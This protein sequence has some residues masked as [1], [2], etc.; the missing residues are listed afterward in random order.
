MPGSARRVRLINQRTLV[1][2]SPATFAGD[3]SL[4]VRIGRIPASLPASRIRNEVHMGSPKLCF[5]VAVAAALHCNFSVAQQAGDTSSGTLAEVVVTGTRIGRSGFD[6][7]VPITVIDAQAIATA[8]FNNVNDILLQTPAVGVGLGMETASYSNDA[9]ATFV[10]LRGLGTDRTLVLVNGRRRVSGTQTSSAVDLTTIPANMVERIEV[11][12]GGASA[13]YGADAVTGVVNVILK[14]DFDGLSLTGRAGLS[15]EHGDGESY[16]VGAY[17]G[18]GFA[19]DRGRMNFAVSYNDEEPFFIR[20]RSFLFPPLNF[21]GN[22]AN[23]GPADGIADEITIEDVRFVQ[24]HPAGTF[25]IDGTRYTV[26][27]QLRQTQNGA[28]FNSGLVG[29]NGGDGY[30]DLDYRSLRL[31]Q[32]TFASLATM[33][34]D[35][36]PGVQLFLESNFASSRTIDPRTPTFD[37]GVVLQRDNP[38][39]PAAVGALMDANDMT[40]LAVS[41]THKDHG[42]VQKTT[43]DR[44]TYNIVAGLDGSIGERLDWELFYQYGRYNQNLTTNSRI[45]SKWF[46]ALD[47]ISDPTTGAPV[48]RNAVARASGC[49]P[50]NIIGQNVATPEALAYIGHARILNV[51]N[52]QQIA[53][54]QATGR[55]LDLPA[56]PLNYAVGMEYREEGLHARD[57]GLAEQG[58]LFFVDN[59]GP[60][61]DARSSVKEAFVETLLPILS[62]APLAQRLDLEGA[63]RF[64]DYDTIGNTVAWKVGADWTPIEDIRFRVTRSSSVRA[65]NLAE[66]FSPGI[67]SDVGVDDPCDI[68]R[69]DLSPNRRANCLALG[70]PAGW[71]DTQLSGRSGLSGGNPDLQEETARSWTVGAI[72]TPRFIDNLRV[73]IDYWKIDIDDAIN[74]ISATDILEKCVDLA[75]IDNVFCGLFTRGADFSVDEIRLSDVNIG[76]LQASGI[77]VQADYSLPLDAFNWPGTLRVRL[78]ATYLD[79][80]EELVDPL[81]PQSLIVRVGEVENPRVLGSLDIGYARG[82]LDVRWTAH[83]I[84]GAE[85]DVQASPEAYDDPDWSAMMTHDIVASYDLSE[86]YD[87]YIGLNNVF[88]QAPPRNPITSWG[89]YEA[90]RYDSIGRFLFVGATARF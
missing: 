16:S 49:V 73:S 44:T 36:T 31:K 52:T 51:R 90:S 77:D 38:F 40:E 60:P 66:L 32:S 59:G 2:A 88:D 14:D 78:N 5:P 82:P 55:L 35:M 20:D 15:A 76:K 81:D 19:A 25:V 30:N 28:L 42:D 41:R 65:P 68:S 26:D 79:E 22:P 69:I 74:A 3:G 21:I 34:Y 71:V 9:G 39:I 56:G 27:P 11:I 63:V 87:V 17:G 13:V 57:D 43:V 18:T 50:L 84:G 23:T 7:P 46:D 48:C 58:L 33:R 80:H 67:R 10:N 61:A 53:G 24:T 70:A 83:Y 1:A 86:D 12:T 45:E 72:L 85:V 37:F 29:S 89:I 54:L 62:D 47:V 6:T 8:G 64:S 75:S 4:V